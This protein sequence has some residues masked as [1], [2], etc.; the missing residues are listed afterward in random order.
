MSDVHPLAAEATGTTSDRRRTAADIAGL[1]AG[2]LADPDAIEH[3]FEQSVLMEAGRPGLSLSVGF[4]AAALFHAELA[5]TRPAARRTA[6]AMLAR[7]ISQEPPSGG[8]A[9][10]DGLTALA[11]AARNT[12]A[13]ADDYRFL[14]SQLDP[15]VADLAHLR[16]ERW[17]QR[18]PATLTMSSYDVIQGLTGLGRYL[19]MAAPGGDALREVLSFLVSITDEPAEAAGHEVPGW[20]VTGPPWILAQ[21][22]PR[23]AHGHANLGL[24][25]GISGPLALL[26]I[27]WREG[28]RVPGQR[29]AIDSITDFLLRWRRPDEFGPRWP[30][31]LT[32]DQLLGR[33]EPGVVCNATWCYGVPGI[34]RAIQLA[35]LALDRADWLRV[36]DEAMRSLVDRPVD[37][38]Y[39]TAAGLCHGWA[40]LLQIA[41]RIAA[42]STDEAASLVAGLAAERT[43]EHFDPALPY[44]FRYPISADEP[45][46][47][48]AGLLDGAGGTA[49]ALHA[50]ARGSAPASQWDAA[51][52]IS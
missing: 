40:G 4:P 22:D 1:L 12:A 37:Q 27:A 41:L 36:A 2:R 13:T 6:H 11:F 39:L 50:Y 43:I 10:Y 42:D 20:W 28:Q 15:Y 9:L 49:L 26:A 19:L 8:G 45:P 38:L 33:E 31:V 7:A 21:H 17:S 44:G 29:Q 24:A 51:L 16:V 52:L 34:A 25:H 3:L 30:G 32:L 47:D 5:A 18:G 46:T 48:G 14:L 35:G 23:Y